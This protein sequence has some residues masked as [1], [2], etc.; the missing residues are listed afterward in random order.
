M[1]SSDMLFR[2]ADLSLVVY[3]LALAGVGVLSI[4]ARVPASVAAKYAPGVLRLSQRPFAFRW[5]ED[6]H[7]EDLPVF[8]KARVWHHVFVMALSFLPLLAS[9]YHYAYTVVELASCHTQ[10]ADILYRR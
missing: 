8:E 1:P 6:V 4:R 10:L 7:R 9:M 5:R 2:L 3:L